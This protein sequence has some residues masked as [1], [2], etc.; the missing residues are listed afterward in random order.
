VAR[1]PLELISYIVENDR[2]FSEILTANYTVLN[3]YTARIYNNGGLTFENEQSATEFTE[4]AIFAHTERG[5]ERYPHAGVLSSPMFLNR[6]PTS[7]TNRNRHRARMLFEKFLATDI[8]KIGARPIDPT[9]AV[10]FAN[11]TRE[12]PDC[13]M[14]HSIIDPV[15]GAFMHFSDNDQEQLVDREWFPEMLLPGFDRDQMQVSDYGRALPWVA[16]RIAQDPRFPLSVVYNTFS[17]L[18]SQAPLEYPAGGEEHA[19]NAWQAQETT[20]R[21]ISQRFVE[22]GYNY[23]TVVREI[24]LSAYFRGKN[25]NE[26]AVAAHPGELQAYGIG[27]LSTPEALAR[28]VKAIVGFDW[29][30]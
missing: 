25:V 5:V 16:E 18:T 24:V 27:R 2:P 26:E 7:P 3:P 10:A 14:C 13:S 21:A 6:F 4:A 15:A 28:K 23:K 11:P 9:E 29:V 22:E 20:L 19:F 30:R 8:L 12:D 17:A 1:E